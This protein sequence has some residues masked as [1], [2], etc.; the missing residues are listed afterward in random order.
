MYGHDDEAV[1]TSESPAAVSSPLPGLPPAPGRRGLPLIGST[2]EFLSGRLWNTRERYDRYGPVSSMRAFGINVIHAQG[3]DAVGQVLQNRDRAYASGPGWSYLIG[4]FFR[5]GLMLLDFDEHHQH[6]RIMQQAFTH[7]RLAGYLDPMNRTLAADLDRWAAGGQ[8]RVYPAIKQLTLD[9]ATRTFMAAQLGPEADRINRAFA[10]CVRAGTAIVRFPVPGGRWAR[11]LAGR[12]ALERFLCPQ[13]A[14]KRASHSSDLFSAL[15]HARSDD[16]DQFSDDDV[17]NHMIFL[18]MAAHDTTT[19]TMTTIA[20]YLARHP[21]WQQ[22]CRD[23][24]L[25]LGTPVLAFTDLDELVSLDMVM[26]ESMRLVTPVPGVVRRA[27]RD[28]ELMGHLVPENTIVTAS[29]HGTHHLREYWPD[30]ERFDP[31]R[32]AGHRREDKVHKH[33]W[34]PFSS[35]V[36]KCIGLHYG[37]MQIKAAVHQMLLRYRWSTPAS[38][39]MPIDWTSL[40]RPKDGLPVHLERL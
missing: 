8:F 19:I 30:P 3:P 21:R 10:D 17:I 35:G 15:C 24:S 9:V 11:G 16:D 37:G 36:H 39:Q 20:Y 38:Y 4:P 23:E 18:L 5:R 33:A 1:T 29:L 6:R 34:I 31:G 27:V 22:R 2:F 28:T 14:A 25:A 40:P 26:K 7:D 13:L 32:F 12:K